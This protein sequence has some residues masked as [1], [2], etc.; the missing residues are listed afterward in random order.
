MKGE[1]GRESEN[2]LACPNCILLQYRKLQTPSL[3]TNH[4]RFAPILKGSNLLQYRKSK[5]Q[6]ATTASFRI[7]KALQM[8]CDSLHGILVPRVQISNSVVKNQKLPA[9]DQTAVLFLSFR[10]GSNTTQTDWIGRK[11]IQSWNRIEKIAG[12]QIQKWDRIEKVARPQRRGTG[13]RK[14]SAR[15]TTDCPHEKQRSSRSNFPDR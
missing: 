15:K 6:K 9:F 10:K 4:M 13:L 2:S 5:S 12:K 7:E 11:Q 14:L 3:C 8:D 1:A